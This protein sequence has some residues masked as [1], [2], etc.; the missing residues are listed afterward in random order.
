EGHR[1]ARGMLAQHPRDLI[2]VEPRQA[3]ID[4]RHVGPVLRRQIETVWPVDGRKHAMSERLEE[5]LQRLTRVVIVLDDEDATAALRDARRG[6][7]VRRLGGGDRQPY[8]E[9]GAAAAALA[10]RGDRAVMH[11]DEPA[12]QREADTEATDRAI[13]RLLRLSE[14]LEDARQHL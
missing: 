14:E 4:Q 12:A 7:G 13:H 6:R 9:L 3:E 8:G 11:L 10:D 1:L 2:A 5:Q